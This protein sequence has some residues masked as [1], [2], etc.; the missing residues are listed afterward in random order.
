MD[1]ASQQWVSESLKWRWRVIALATACCTSSAP[2]GCRGGAGGRSPIDRGPVGVRAGCP[3][4]GAPRPWS[5]QYDCCW[6]GHCPASPSCCVHV[7]L[8]GARPPHRPGCGHLQVG[9]AVTGL[10]SRAQQGGFETLCASESPS[11]TSGNFRAGHS[12]SD[13]AAA[14]QGCCI[15]IPVHGLGGEDM[16]ALVPCFL[17]A[18]CPPRRAV[19][20]VAH[21]THF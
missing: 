9:R 12:G 7:A 15:L 6:G 1:Y 13:R 19:L 14:S 2:G 18:L 20:G 11:F 4:H 10:R 21:S 17:P 3:A 5:W 8:W 16:G